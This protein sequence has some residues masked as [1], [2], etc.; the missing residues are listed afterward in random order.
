MRSEFDPAT[1]P[2]G[3]IHR[4]WVRAMMFAIAL[5]VAAPAPAQDRTPLGADASG[6]PAGTIPAWDGGLKSPL[7]GHRSGSPYADPYEADVPM[8]AIS[9]GNLDRYRAQLSPGQIALLQKYPSWKMNVYPTRR[10]AAFPEAVYEETAAN[11]GV[12]KLAPLGAITEEFY[13]SIFNVNVNAYALCGT[14]HG[15]E[16]SNITNFVRSGA[17]DGFVCGTWPLSA[18]RTEPSRCG[19]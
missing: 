14:R 6:N 1:V 5:V 18:R 7:A 15:I 8:F 4:A 2:A 12:A 3:S 16:R 13:D 9:A 11:A 19:A 17:E 10:S